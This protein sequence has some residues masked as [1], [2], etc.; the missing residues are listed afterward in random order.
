LPAVVIDLGTA[1]TLDVVTQDKSYQGGVILPGVSMGIESLS[2][3]TSLLPLIDMVF[4]E[5]VIG[6]NTMTC[7]QSGTLLGYCDVLDGLLTR[8]Q[9]ELKQEV[10]VTLT[11]GIAPLFQGKLKTSHEYRPHLTLEGTLL[12]YQLNG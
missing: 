2:R 3:N 1:T 4:P 5:R 11:G 9:L 8:I 7:I 10:S 6:K 12:L